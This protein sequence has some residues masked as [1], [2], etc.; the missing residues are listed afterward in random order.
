MRV[1]TDFDLDPKLL[2]SKIPFM[3][4]CVPNVHYLKYRLR[5]CG[6]PV[7]H[8]ILYKPS[9]GGFIDIS[10]INDLA[11]FA[12][13]VENPLEYNLLYCLRYACYNNVKAKYSLTDVALTLSFKV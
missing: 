3:R 9:Q 2:S 8:L 6:F 13:S 5:K 11:L 12:P 7:D 10:T 4:F 1:A